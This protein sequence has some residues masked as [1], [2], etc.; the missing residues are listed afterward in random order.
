[1]NQYLQDALSEAIVVTQ[2]E[3]PC[4]MVRGLDYDDEQLALTN[5]P[6]FWAMIRERRKEPTIP[7]EVAKQQLESLDQ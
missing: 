6:K 4:A 5:S 1:V 2:D 7:W 3:R